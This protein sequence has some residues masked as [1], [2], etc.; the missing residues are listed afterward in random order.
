MGEDASFVAKRSQ[1]LFKL[2]VL[3]LA[4]GLSEHELRPRSALDFLRGVVGA[5]LVREPGE[6]ARVGPDRV[7]QPA[8]FVEDDE[9]EWRPG[10]DLPLEQ[11]DGVW[12]YEGDMIVGA[13]GNARGVVHY[14]QPWP[15][16]QV[17][18][19][20]ARS[21]QYRVDA[22]TKAI[23]RAALAEYREHTDLDIIE[24]PADEEP[25]GDYVE[26]RQWDKG[27]GSAHVGWQGGRQNLSIPGSPSK[28]LVM[29]EFGHSLG[30]GHEHQH[31]KRVRYID[32]DL[33]C[34]EEKHRSSFK[35]RPLADLEGDYDFDSIMHYRSSSFCADDTK[36]ADGDGNRGECSFVND[37]A[38]LGKCY[39]IRRIWGRCSLEVCTDK[40]GDGFREYIKGAQRPSPGDYDAI[41]RL[42]EGMT[43]AS[44][45][46]GEEH[47]KLH[48]ADTNGDRVPE[49]WLALPRQG[50][51][52]ELWEFRPDSTGKKMRFCAAHKVNW[53][54][55]AKKAG[56]KDFSIRLQS[57]AGAAAGGDSLFVA[58]SASGTDGENKGAG[59]RQAG[60]IE[61]WA[62]RGKTA[63][64]LQHVRKWVPSASSAKDP[65]NGALHLSGALSWLPP[66]TS[67]KP[68]A[69]LAGATGQGGPGGAYLIWVDPLRDRDFG[70]DEQAAVLEVTPAQKLK[71]EGLDAARPSHG[72]AVAI[73]R[74]GEELHWAVGDRCAAGDAFPCR[75]RIRSGIWGQSAVQDIELSAIA[76][77][78]EAIAGDSELFIH[79]VS[80]SSPGLWWANAGFAWA[81]A[82][83]TKSRGALL[84]LEG[85]AGHLRFA[86]LD[87][88]LQRLID[89]NVNGL[90]SGFRPFF[91]DAKR[92]I[93]RADR[94][95]AWVWDQHGAHAKLWALPMPSLPPQTPLSALEAP[96]VGWVEDDNDYYVLS[97]E[98]DAEGQ[99]RLKLI[100]GDRF[101][102]FAP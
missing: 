9:P 77:A 18:Y 50:K 26:V 16:A 47:P 80:G 60:W 63:S 96:Y 42:H 39:P 65:Q 21:Q 22:K 13:P 87:R 4:I 69:L 3:G 99:Q 79:P 49:A 81:G 11:R 88:R 32:I 51:C 53:R 97:T 102:G 41:N 55:D 61:Q 94:G 86:K 64:G 73:W 83:S 8:R 29:H 6:A 82:E 70:E 101:E 78:G 92:W 35:F 33:D 93:L 58:L 43:K 20:F 25:S 95:R 72:A 5:A 100:R 19:S 59:D 17:R 84:R 62:R 48:L 85:R 14:G 89:D 67:A 34:V 15:C 40:D 30:L 28:R 36:D 54:C 46:A 98:T 23:V 1:H 68:G 27:W 31:P 90:G 10:D 91:G 38:D 7:S 44:W 66:D 24:I 76:E 37:D 57:G 2:A 45:P 71:E 52:G 56:M 74:Q 12:V 75:P